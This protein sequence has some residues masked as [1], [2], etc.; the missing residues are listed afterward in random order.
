ML[1]ESLLGDDLQSA[2]GNITQIIEQQPFIAHIFLKY[3]WKHRPRYKNV[4]K[5][6]LT[7]LP[8]ALPSRKQHPLE[9]ILFYLA[10]LA[11]DSKPSY[12]RKLSNEIEGIFSDME[13]GGTLG[14][15]HAWIRVVFKR[16]G[17][18]STQD[19]AFFEEL[20]IV[21]GYL[22]KAKTVIG[23]LHA[24]WTDNSVSVESLPFNYC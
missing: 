19:R 22:P 10:L 1:I 20:E 2:A 3:L 4:T 6:I 21:T 12:A 14:L 23:S 9:L 15:I 18:S 16:H 11:K 8:E 24:A 17:I 5:R 13:F 7:N